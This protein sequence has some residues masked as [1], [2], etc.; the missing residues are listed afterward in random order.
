VVV[1][2]LAPYRADAH[3]VVASSFL[4]GGA[5]SVIISTHTPSRKAKKVFSE[6]FY[7]ALLGGA[8]VQTALRKVQS[9]MIRNPEFSSPLVWG[10]YM[11]W[12]Q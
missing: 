7:T 12:G 9:E 5:S 11:L 10:P 4:S 2:N 8:D 3:V 6:M 1:S